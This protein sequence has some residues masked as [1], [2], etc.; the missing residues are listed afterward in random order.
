MAKQHGS[1]EYEGCH[2]RKQWLKSSLGNEYAVKYCPM[3][4]SGSRSRTKEIGDKY[5]DTNGYVKI[6][7]GVGQTVGEHRFVME[8]T[9][10][11]VLTK[12]ESV[13]HKKGNREDNRPENL[14]LWVG[15]I[16]YGQRA[17]DIVCPHCDKPY[18]ESNQ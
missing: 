8:Q 17:T 18:L 14:E 5:V 7:L 16:R 12:G 10:G 2:L 6:Y 1:C 4:I 15:A 9:L 3:H 11:R 13:H